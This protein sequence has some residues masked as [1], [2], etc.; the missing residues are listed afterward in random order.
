MAIRVEQSF[1]LYA[2]CSVKYDGRA[3]STLIPGNYLI[4]H[5]N[6]GTL[7]IDGGSLCTPLNYQP[8][9]AIL[10]K[11]KDSLISIRKNEKITIEIDKIHYYQELRN[12]SSN[13]IEIKKTEA[14]LRDKIVNKIDKILKVKTIEV[15]KEFK[16]PVGDI[17]ILAIDEYDTY[18]IVEVK[19]G[20]ANLA[21]C[22]QLERYCF[23]FVDIMKNVKDYIASPDISDNALRYA[24][25]NYQTYLKVEHSI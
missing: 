13:K 19:R 7:R 21:T 1:V 10:H 16:T 24:N 22:S 17:D 20:K 12:W 15:F 5:K 4:T 18:H 9:G 3:K 25:E 23:Y 8:P 11:V 6:D 14:Q 2:F